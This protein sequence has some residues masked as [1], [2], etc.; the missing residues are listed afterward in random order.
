MVNKHVALA[1][2]KRNAGTR[3]G[4]RDVSIRKITISVPL[5]ADA[6]TIYMINAMTVVVQPSNS[7]NNQGLTHPRN[8]VEI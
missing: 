5:V 6:H 1:N 4:G 8:G 3:F 7:R 2:N